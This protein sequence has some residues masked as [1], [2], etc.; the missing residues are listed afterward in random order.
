MKAAEAMVRLE[1]RRRQLVEER[2]AVE[3]ACDKCGLRL[4]RLR[5]QRAK[6]ERELA[7]LD[8]AL[9]ALR[10]DE[11]PPTEEMH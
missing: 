9:D 1:E 11:D 6:Q 2:R 4:D 8:R 7:A 5:Q 10:R 3:E